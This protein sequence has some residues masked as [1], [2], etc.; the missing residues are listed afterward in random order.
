MGEG[1]NEIIFRINPTI[2]KYVPHRHRAT[3]L[4]SHDLRSSTPTPYVPQRLAARTC[5]EVPFDT[6]RGS[7]HYVW[8]FHSL[9]LETPNATTTQPLRSVAVVKSKPNTSYRAHSLLLFRC[10]VPV[11]HSHSRQVAR[12]LELRSRCYCQESCDGTHT[13]LF[14]FFS[15]HK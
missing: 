14:S 15:P 5:L 10:Q 1:L 2:L 9:R 6:F 7:I 8:R 11:S 3:Y 12:Q 4:D 13:C